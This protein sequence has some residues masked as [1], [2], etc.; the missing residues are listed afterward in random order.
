MNRSG[1]QALL[2]RCGSDLADWPEAERLAAEALLDR[3]PEAGNLIAQA[4]RLERLLAQSLGRETQKAADDAALRILSRLS[5]NLPE[6]EPVFRQ[7]AVSAGLLFS[8]TSS[9]SLPRYA[10]LTFAAALGMA[11]GVFSADRQAIDDRQSMSLA[12]DDTETDLSALLFDND[13]T[14][15]PS[16]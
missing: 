12:F 8:L 9:S 3:D 16:Q 10:A 13:S 5:R 11:V 2:D 6:Q 4:R 14:A 15:G 1:L 7:K